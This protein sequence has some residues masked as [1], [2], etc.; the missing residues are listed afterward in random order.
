M[1]YSITIYPKGYVE[2][3]N[4]N[5][6]DGSIIIYFNDIQ[7]KDAY[8]ASESKYC[9]P[10]FRDFGGATTTAARKETKGILL[11][12]RTAY[13]RSL[14]YSHAKGTAREWKIQEQEKMRA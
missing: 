14:G 1:R 9:E 10:Q 7:E 13:A 5:G 6:T 2:K 3:D 11:L 12:R 4:P 8:I